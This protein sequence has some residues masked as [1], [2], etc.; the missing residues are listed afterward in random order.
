MATASRAAGGVRRRYREA[1]SGLRVLPDYLVIGA[2]RAGST[3][4]HDY[5][6]GHPHVDEPTHKELHFFDQNHWRGE[7]WYRRHFPSRLARA[8]HERRTGVRPVVGEASPYYLFHPLVP[9]RVRAT[10]PDARLVVLLRNPVERAYSHHQLAVRQGLESLSFEDALAAEP[11]R[12]A[13]EEERLRADPRYR[14]DGHR[15]HAY[16]ARGLYAEQLERWLGLFPRDQLLILRSENL[17]ADPAAVHAEVIRF[18]GLDPVEL[19]A[20][21]ARNQQAY[22]PMPAETRRM[23]EERFAEPNRRLAELLGR[24]FDWSGSGPA[25]PKHPAGGVAGGAEVAGR[26]EAEHR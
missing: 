3:S 13:G 22:A 9:E 15:H 10:L 4:L 23:L 19:P 2:Q 14:S 7:G 21:V 1:T 25:E 16:F 6:V 24:D 5:L 12:L 18:L 26:E 20:Y 8:A 17:F 11:D